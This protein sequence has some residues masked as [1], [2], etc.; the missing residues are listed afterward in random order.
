[1]DEAVLLLSLNKPIPLQVTVIVLMMMLMTIVIMIMLMTMIITMIMLT[2][3]LTVM[4]TKS[5][6]SSDMLEEREDIEVS[7][8]NDLLKHCVDHNVTA[9][10]DDYY[11]GLQSL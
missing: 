4:M 9:S 3:M 7:P 2:M 11:D 8:G 6:L 10:P 5:N 1:M